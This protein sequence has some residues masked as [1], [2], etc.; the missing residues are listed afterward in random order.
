MRLTT[1]LL[2]ISCGL[3]LAAC[4]GTTDDECTAEKASGTSSKFATS[5]IKLPGATTPYA[6][7]IDGDGRTDNQLKALISTV[8]SQG[9]DLQMSL[10][11]AV[12]KGD[13]IIL[14]DILSADLMNGCS[15]VTL[16][17]ADKVAADPKYDGTDS[18]K[19]RAGS[20]SATLAGKITTGSLSTILP[21]DQKGDQVQQIRL[22]LPLAEGADL[23]LTIYGAHIQGKVSAN[24]V[25]S[26]ELHGVIRKKDIDEG[27]IPT[28]AKLL[29]DQVKK[30]GNSAK[31]IIQIFEDMTNP[32]S[33]MKCDTMP[34]KCCAKN[35]TTCEITAEEVR[36]N[37]L[38]GQL[39][40]PDVQVFQN[41]VWMPVPKGTMKDAM[42]VGLG[43]TSVKASF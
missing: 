29:T 13:A 2:G 32:A 16:N 43:F 36:T 22:T 26:G 27:I 42:S 38:I 37:G 35:P 17:I 5:A 1:K 18:F 15:K 33:K 34:M 12:K 21:K 4:G 20:I 24:G 14:A 30:G 8:Q 7:D 31:L 23:P 25:M 40:A 19:V 28:V 3:L 41:D 11:D 39:L 10:D 6:I 9:F